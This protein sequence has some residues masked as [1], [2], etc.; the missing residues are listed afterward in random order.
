MIKKLK[1]KFVLINMCLVSLVLLIVFAVIGVYTF[2]RAKDESLIAMDKALNRDFGSAP[3]FMEIG[4]KTPEKHGPL[5]PVFRVIVDENQAITNTFRDNVSVS[6]DIVSEVTKIALDS[7]SPSGYLTKYELRFMIRQTPEGVKIAFADTTREKETMLN[8]LIVLLL[9]GL[10]ALLAFLL[11]SIYLSRWALKPVEI[12]W[13]QQKQFV[14]DA[15]HELKTPL[16]VILANT[17]ILLSHKQDSVATQVKWIENTKTEAKRMKQLVEDLLFLAKYDADHKPE[18][19]S[20][21]NLSDILWRC[22]LPFESLAYESGVTIDADIAPNIQLHGNEGQLKQ[23]AMILLDNACKY[24]GANG[25]ITISLKQ[26]GDTINFKIHNT[27]TII[28]PEHQKHIFDRFYRADSARTRE[29]GGYGLG[30]AIASTIVES[31]NGSI[32]VSSSE[33]LGTTFTVQF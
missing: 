8:L 21:L 1:H 4:K 23:L 24:A 15:S 6:D 30:L 22:I 2:D 18:I 25:K 26:Q 12:A 20:Q 7:N 3:P 19:L 13:E 10:G 33:V 5:I 11:I 14:A 29:Q 9:V 27:G 31:H 16:T 17:D 32:G 28:D